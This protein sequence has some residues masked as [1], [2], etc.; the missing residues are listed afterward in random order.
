[1]NWIGMWHKDRFLF[2]FLFSNPFL[3]FLSFNNIIK[4][5]FSLMQY[6]QDLHLAFPNDILIGKKNC[7]LWKWDFRKLSVYDSLHEIIVEFIVLW[8]IYQFS[9][10]DILCESLGLSW[11]CSHFLW[12]SWHCWWLFHS[13]LQKRPPV[14]L[15]CSCLLSEPVFEHQ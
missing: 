9:D 3:L 8:I 11:S 5:L 2:P 12:T 6:T 13:S 4:W 7:Y 14:H 1:M 10:K 15:Q